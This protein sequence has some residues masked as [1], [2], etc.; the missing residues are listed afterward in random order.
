MISTEGASTTSDV[1]DL[2]SVGGG[3]PEL[4]HGSYGLARGPLGSSGP[5]VLGPWLLGA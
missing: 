3:T 2:A 4:A 5:M 1:G